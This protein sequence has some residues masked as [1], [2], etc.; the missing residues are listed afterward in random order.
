[1]ADPQ[2]IDAPSQVWRVARS[3]APLDM[4]YISPQDF[5]RKRAGNRFDTTSGGVLYGATDLVGCYSETLARFRPSAKVRA[6]VAEE[7]GFM[8]CGG[9]PADWRSRRVKVCVELPD[10]LPFLDVESDDTHEYLTTEL[11]L[12][13]AALKVATLDVGLV[14]GPDRRIT[15]AIATWAF[16][17]GLMDDTPRFSGIRYMSRLGNHECWAIF[18]GTPVIELRRDTVAVSDPDLQQVADKFELRLF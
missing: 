17:A 4:S 10:A 11:A 16:H 1:M 9:V 13:L 7:P 8:V 2:V 15:R 18:E 14:R 12:E 3:D 5:R 6:A